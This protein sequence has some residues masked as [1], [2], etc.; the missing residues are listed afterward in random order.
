MRQAATIVVHGDKC[1]LAFGPTVSVSE[2]LAWIKRMMREGLACDYIW[3]LTSDG[4]RR[5][6][7][8]PM[9]KVKSVNK[10]LAK[11]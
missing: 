3:H 1:E 9:P 6:Y 11:V 2:H 5:K 7:H 10:K 4:D 8:P